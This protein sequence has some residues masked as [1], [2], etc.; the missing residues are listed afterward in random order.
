MIRVYSVPQG[1]Q[2]YSFTRGFTNTTQYSLSFS[3]DS[4]FLLSSSDTG[5]IHLFQLFSQ[6]EGKEVPDGANVSNIDEKLMDE[7]ANKAAVP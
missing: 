4:T 1:D 6:Q 7:V 2:L 5:T 3:N